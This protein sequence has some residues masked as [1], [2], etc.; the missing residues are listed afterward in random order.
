MTIKRASSV[1]VSFPPAQ[2][3]CMQLEMLTRRAPFSVYGQRHVPQESMESMPQIRV[4]VMLK[5]AA[6]SSV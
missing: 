4:M 3:Q 2:L 5:I 1:G 6:F